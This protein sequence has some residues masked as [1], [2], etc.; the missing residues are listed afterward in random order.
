MVLCLPSNA[1]AAIGRESAV[2]AWQCPHLPA[3]KSG[4]IDGSETI[5]CTHQAA[6]LE[7]QATVTQSQSSEVKVM[8]LF[9]LDTLPSEA[10]YVQATSQL[11]ANLTELQMQVLRIQFEQ[12]GRA[13]T[14]HQ[15]R[16]A[17][18]YNSI[19]TSNSLY[20][21]LARKFAEQLQMRTS[22]SDESKPHHWR[23]LSTG[24]G[25]GDHYTW[26]MRPE[27]A[28]ALIIHNLVDQSADGATP[29]EDLDIHLSPSAMEGRSRLIQHLKR[30]RNRRIVGEKKRRAKSLGCE[31][32]G[33]DASQFYGIDYC[34]VHHLVLLSDLNGEV[35]TR[36]DDLAILCANCHR[37]VHTVTPPMGLN[38]LRAK[39]ERR[40]TTRFIGR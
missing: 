30:E 35:E 28:K 17:F 24:D 8:S 40:R 7:S 38:E 11:K 39:L 25:S 5:R 15:I 32:C 6:R 1:D 4:A 23:S 16:D 34:E 20:G 31:V 19:G 27:V 26:I 18:G 22:R 10:D 37:I 36:L 14:S 33:F 13:I 3:G 2:D 12:P 9:T 29:Y 21:R